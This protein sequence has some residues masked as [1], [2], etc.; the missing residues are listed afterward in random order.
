MSDTAVPLLAASGATKSVAVVL[1][2][3]QVLHAEARWPPRDVSKTMGA[4]YRYDRNTLRL[5]LLK[6]RDILEAGEP[7][8]TFEFDAAFILKALG[9]TVAQLMTAITTRIP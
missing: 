1:A 6:V 8:Y 2:V 9:M 3:S 4:D 7:P 5:F